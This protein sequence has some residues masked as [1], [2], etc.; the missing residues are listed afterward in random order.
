MVSGYVLFIPLLLI[1]PSVVALTWCL[2]VEHTNKCANM[3]I[4]KVYGHLIPEQWWGFP[5]K[6][7]QNS[8]T[9]NKENECISKGLRDKWL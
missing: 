1:A 2:R 5:F 8:L 6:F 4:Y 7:K 3:L 9:I